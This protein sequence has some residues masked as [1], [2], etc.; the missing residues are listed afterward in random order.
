MPSSDPATYSLVRS[1]I[2]EWLDDN[3]HFGDADALIADDE[4][5]FLENGVLDSLG[6]VQLI[7]HI[8][9]RFSVT[10]ERKDLTRE[11]FDGMRKIISY[12]TACEGFTA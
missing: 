3:V 5:S 4:M 8:E 7:L 1:V 9:G 11:T 6:F 10:L 2:I 12:V